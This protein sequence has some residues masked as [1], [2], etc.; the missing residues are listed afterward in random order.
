MTRK[1]SREDRAASRPGARRSRGPQELVLDVDQLLRR[2]DRADVRLE[3]GEVSLRKRPLVDVLRNRPHDLKIGVAS[4]IGWYRRGR[5]SPVGPCHRRRKCSATSATAGPRFELRRR[6]S[7]RR[8][9]PHAPTCRRD[10][11]V[12]CEIDAPDDATRSSM[13]IV[14]SWWQCM[15]RTHESSPQWISFRRH[16]RSTIRSRRSWTV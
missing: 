11:L 9:A 2:P 8:L 16:M 13:T 6:A 14:F 4:R 15:K 12:Q 1:S 7:R 5:V 10:L 3:Q